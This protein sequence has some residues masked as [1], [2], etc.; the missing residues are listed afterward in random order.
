MQNSV[1]SSHFSSWEKRKREGES[2][3]KNSLGFT[4]ML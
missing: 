3:I 2:K 4:K 1:K